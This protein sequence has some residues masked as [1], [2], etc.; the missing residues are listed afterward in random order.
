[1]PWSS[2]SSSAI[3]GGE[4]DH[5]TR[6]A[7]APAL[8]AHWGKV[9]ARWRKGKRGQEEDEIRLARLHA[10]LPS[11]F[12]TPAAARFALAADLPLP[13]PSSPSTSG[14][15]HAPA[16]TAERPAQPQPA[17][18]PRLQRFWGPAIVSGPSRPPSPSVRAGA[19]LP[20]A[21][22]GVKAEP[23]AAN[24]PGA[25]LWSEVNVRTVSRV[26]RI[27]ARLFQFAAGEVWRV[28]SPSS[29]SEG[30]DAAAGASPFGPRFELVAFHSPM[31]LV[32][33]PK[34]TP[35]SVLSCRRVF[36]C[37][38]MHGWGERASA[39]CACMFC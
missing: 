6:L 5:P 17:T 31:D 16:P 24:P 35:P 37:M 9:S 32:V 18:Y 26:A 30:V 22:H 3:A 36:V 13:S 8:C 34:V 11:R 1:M 12:L 21:S 27:C 4:G 15:T 10:H 20:L 23:A 39:G 33:R 7:V 2:S 25:K 19:M 14:A 38:C 28:H 29:G